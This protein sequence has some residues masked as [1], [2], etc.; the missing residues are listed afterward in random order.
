M[1]S[2]ERL[3]SASEFRDIDLRPRIIEGVDINE[4]SL[5]ALALDMFPDHEISPYEVGNRAVTRVTARAGA[6]EQ[7]HSE[8]DLPA[9]P[10]TAGFFSPSP[11]EI[12]FFGCVRPHPG[13][14]AETTVADLEDVLGRVEEEPLRANTYQY[15]TPKRMGETTHPF[16]VLQE[17]DGLPFLRFRRDYTESPDGLIDRVEQEI[18]RAPYVAALREGDVLFH[19]NGAPHGRFPQR[20]PTPE[21]PD[22]R[23][24]LLRCRLKRRRR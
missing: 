15:R 8:N 19:W 12:V 17:V 6:T 24:M 20:G 2:P 5:V 23:R 14:G 16:R 9:P 1:K 3:K 7:S 22:R 21:D 13:G 4:E 18:K 11:P 10:H